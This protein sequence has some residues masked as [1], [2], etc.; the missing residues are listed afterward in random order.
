MYEKGLHE[1]LTDLLMNAGC[2]V[3]KYGID[4]LIEFIALRDTAICDDLQKNT[5]RTRVRLTQTT[6]KY[7]PVAAPKD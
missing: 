6:D 4:K 7:L 1:E 3:N 2:A 5:D